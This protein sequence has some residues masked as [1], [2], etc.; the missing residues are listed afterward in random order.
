MNNVVNEYGNII[1]VE[2]MYQHMDE[3]I[4]EQLN[5]EIPEV[6]EQEYFEHYCKLYRFLKGKEF[7]LNE[8]NPQF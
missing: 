8:K 5:R 2:V 3:E 4:C 7:F 1:P 6:E